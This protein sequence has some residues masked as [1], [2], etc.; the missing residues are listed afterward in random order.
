[1]KDATHKV[2]FRFGKQLWHWAIYRAGKP[3]EAPWS[4]R[5]AAGGMM[6]PSDTPAKKLLESL[7]E[8]IETIRAGLK[9]AQI[10]T[11]D[12]VVTAWLTVPA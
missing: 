8:D 10:E 2:T 11:E 4:F 9:T 12:G 6:W 1:M 3:G 7:A 5:E